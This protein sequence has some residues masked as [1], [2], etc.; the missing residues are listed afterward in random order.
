MAGKL[1]KIYVESPSSSDEISWAA[2]KLAAGC[3]AAVPSEIGTVV[4]GR[5]DSASARTSI[6]T[7]CTRGSS[8]FWTVCCGEHAKAWS[9]WDPSVKTDWLQRLLHICWPGPLAVAAPGSHNALLGLNGKCRKIAA[10][11]PGHALC[12]NIVKACD[13]PLVAGKLPLLSG[14]FSPGEEDVI[15]MCEKHCDMF[16]H[17]WEPPGVMRETR[18]DIGRNCSRLLKLG[19]V[20]VD[21]LKLLLPH[22]LILS[23]D[24]EEIVSGQE[25]SSAKIIVFEGDSERVIRRIRLFCKELEQGQCVCFAHSQAVAQ[26]LK[27]QLEVFPI[28][29][30]G[31]E[32]DEEQPFCW[33][34]I[35]SSVL[36]RIRR[37]E[38]SE[39]L[40]YVLVE[41]T[42]RR[43]DSAE[44][45]PEELMERLEKA[46]HQI[47]NTDA[48]RYDDF[49]A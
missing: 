20:S 7:V 19:A 2:S 38:E 46:A 43:D 44:R 48:N 47:I 18:I 42:S 26:A 13:F 29:D 31:I 14:L 27:E 41:G 17:G 40:Q 37:C 34:R 15:A 11:M 24:A 9:Y 30:P 23:C 10:W 8:A 16:I 6:R 36:E 21:T 32:I 22:S 12:R 5:A 28:L 35:G 33:Q 25:A 45:L 3:T 4:L 49:E 1:I 39:D